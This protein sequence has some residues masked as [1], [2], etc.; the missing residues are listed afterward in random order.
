[1]QQENFSVLQMEGFSIKKK[2]FRVEE[3]MKKIS[4][5]ISTIAIL[6]MTLLITGGI[7]VQEI[8]GG[9]A[10]GLTESNGVD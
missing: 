9:T 8:T 10:P 2:E 7:A 3:K 4:P 6:L 1:M 5:K